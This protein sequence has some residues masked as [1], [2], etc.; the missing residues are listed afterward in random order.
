MLLV[1]DAKTNYICNMETR[2]YHKLTIKSVHFIVKE[3]VTTCYIKYF[4]PIIGI[5][6]I[7]KGT[8]KCHP[9]DKFDF[10]LGQ[11][12]AD[13]RAKIAMYSAYE[14]TLRSTID[15]FW[16]LRAKYADFKCNEIVHLGDITV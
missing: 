7:A 3:H 10:K 13:S 15:E 8:A 16:K 9:D 4:N 11:H 1:L 14:D 12:I 2:H 6:K 5:W